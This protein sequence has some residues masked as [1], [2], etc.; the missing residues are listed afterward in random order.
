MYPQMLKVKIQPL[1]LSDLE[2]IWS[3]TFHKWSHKQANKY[4]E[5][6]DHAIN[7]IAT[8]PNTGQNIVHVKKKYWRYK[9]NH[10]YI[11][12]TKTKTY[13]KIIRI[14][15]EKMDSVRHLH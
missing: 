9:I 10:H 8:D 7:T 13:I 2:E 1:A 12:Y 6:I 4:S 11:F 14:L 15:H 3:Y 5:E